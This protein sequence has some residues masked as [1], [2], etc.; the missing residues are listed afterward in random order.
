MFRGDFNSAIEYDKQIKLIKAVTLMIFLFEIITK[1]FYIDHYT[2][3]RNQLAT[4][5][6]LL[7]RPTSIVFQQLLNTYILYLAYDVQ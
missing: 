5:T 4:F 1:L 6:F 3:T 7:V 2:K